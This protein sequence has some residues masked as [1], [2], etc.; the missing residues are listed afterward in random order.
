MTNEEF[1]KRV[2]FLLSRQ[3]DFET[4][5][6]RVEEIQPLHAKALTELI[7]VC[8]TLTD[9][10]VNGYRAVFESLERLSES[11]K[12]TDERMKLTDQKI[13]ALID[14]QIRADERFERHRREDHGLSDA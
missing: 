3:A 5:M 7:N 10:V 4:R 11:M 14:S 8:A 13:D 12:D 1:N 2:E 6:Q 9:T